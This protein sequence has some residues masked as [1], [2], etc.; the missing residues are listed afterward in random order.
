MWWQ[1]FDEK[2]GE[3][4]PPDFGVVRTIVLKGPGVETGG[5]SLAVVIVFP[6]DK[7]KT[8]AP[9]YDQKKNPLWAQARS[10]GW[11]TGEFRQLYGRPQIWRGYP[12]DQGPPNLKGKA[13]GIY[14]AKLGIPLEPDFIAS[15]TSPDSDKLHAANGVT[16]SLVGTTSAGSDLPEGNLSVVHF[17]NNLKQAKG[18]VDMF[19]EKKPPFDEIVAAGVLKE[20]IRGAAYQVVSDKTDEAAI[21]KLMGA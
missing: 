8:I 21:K 1:V 4:G 17:H 12:G 7:L 19:N 11:L 16:G 14:S 2:W 3:Q 6:D 20:P 9:F 15:F 10:D 13:M 18:L 5:D